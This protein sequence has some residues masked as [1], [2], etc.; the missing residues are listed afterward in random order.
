MQLPAGHDLPHTRTRT[1]HWLVT[2]AF[3]ATVTAVAALCQ[4]SDATAEPG[5][6][7]APAADPRG[8]P[9]PA[10]D[11][12]TVDFPLDCGSLGVVVT[13]RAT[14]DLGGD[15]WPETV[16]AVR[17]DAGSGTPPHGLYLLT[18]SG[19]DG[20]GAEDAAVLAE[21][22][23]DPAE[24]MTVDGLETAGDGTISARLVGYSSPDVPRC[25]PDLRRDVSWVW[26]DGR[27]EL[28]PAPTPNSV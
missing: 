19:E 11:P 13:D 17:C 25:C 26:Q 10:P 6:V 4:P 21:T 23:V 24:G 5:T 3:L 15:G 1:V 14:L 8:E 7:A 28:R 22:L 16:A 2:A 20:G 9:R 18:G 12:G 27:L